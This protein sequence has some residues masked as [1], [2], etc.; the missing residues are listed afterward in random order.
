M[1]ASV[2]VDY[3]VRF[4][5]GRDVSPSTPCSTRLRACCYLTP[6]QKSQ[7]Y[8]LAR[9]TPTPDDVRLDEIVRPNVRRLL[10]W[11][12]RRLSSS[13]AAQRCWPATRC[14]ER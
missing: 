12:T 7:L 8:T 9:G 2:S 13:G 10:E 11:L 14:P 6:P 4:E 5:Q 1:L 3:Y